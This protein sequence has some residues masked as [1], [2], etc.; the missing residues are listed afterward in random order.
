MGQV[1]AAGQ[2]DRTLGL[3]SR[4]SVETLRREL[5][6]ALSVCAAAQRLGIGR[7]AALDFVRDDLL[8]RAVRTSAG[9]KIPVRSVGDLED[10]CESLP[11]IESETS[12]WVS[13]RQAT[14]IA[15]PSG[16][17][18]SHILKRIQ[19]GSLAARMAEPV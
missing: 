17:A 4:C 2:H 5:G 14:Q 6:G 1:H 7:H 18:M 3:V 12:T 19:A 16:L 11:P 10:F 8:P 9:W 15:G 13:L